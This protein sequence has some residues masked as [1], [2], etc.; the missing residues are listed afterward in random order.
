MWSFGFGSEGR[1]ELRAARGLICVGCNTILG[2]ML[3]KSLPG[4]DLCKKPSIAGFTRSTGAIIEHVNVGGEN[5]FHVIPSTRSE[6]TEIELFVDFACIVAACCG[7]HMSSNSMV[8]FSK[9]WSLGFVWVSTLILVARW[10]LPVSE[11]KRGYH[12]DPWQYCREHKI[13]WLASEFD[14]RFLSCV[15]VI[16]FLVGTVICAVINYHVGS[17]ERRTIEPFC[18]DKYTTRVANE[19]WSILLPTSTSTSPANTTVG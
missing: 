3:C 16:C 7:K 8:Q 15:L 12:L 19:N 1:H 11:P 4:F 14:W 5:V 6:F 2:L 10:L 13:Y 18:K 9:S 17:Q